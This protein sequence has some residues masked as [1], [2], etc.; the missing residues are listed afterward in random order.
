M[1]DAFRAALGG[2]FSCGFVYRGRRMSNSHVT[3]LS[4][5]Y[6]A[7]HDR[8][9]SLLVKRGVSTS[10]AADIVHDAFVRMLRTPANDL[11]NARS[12]LFKTATNIAIDEYRRQRR[13]SRIMEPDPDFGLSVPDAAPQPDAVLIASDQIAALHRALA[14]LPPR[15]REVLLLSKFE[16]LT[17][18]EVGE[19]LGIAKNTVMAHL[20]KAITILRSRLRDVSSP[21]V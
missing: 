12:Y 8:L 3:D 19:R 13:T 1:W 4:S 15:T 14:D 17:Y 5:L 20:A 10:M 21:T 7:E 2:A 11:A 9:T 6:A 16:G 18:V